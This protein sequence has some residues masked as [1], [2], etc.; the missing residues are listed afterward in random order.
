ML[1]TDERVAVDGASDRYPTTGVMPA[2]N[3]A[4]ASY[5]SRR[6]DPSEGGETHERSIQRAGVLPCSPR[7]RA[8]GWWLPAGPTGNSRK[9]TPVNTTPFPLCILPRL[10]TS[11]GVAERAFTFDEISG[12]F[13]SPES[14]T[15]GVPPLLRGHDRSLHMLRF[16]LLAQARRAV[17]G[18]AGSG[19]GPGA[20]F[21]VAAI[22]AP[23]HGD[24]LRSDQDQL[25]V[26]AIKRVPM[27][28]ERALVFGGGRRQVMRERSGSSPGRLMPD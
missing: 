23:G 20:G 18:D 9:A 3:R 11:D 2:G 28:G 13:W 19:N 16:H 25:Q 14:G 17:A 1:I 22:D 12:L 8:W 5:Q 4:P 15:D 21:T 27:A 10:T 7:W 26:D 6:R 24:Q